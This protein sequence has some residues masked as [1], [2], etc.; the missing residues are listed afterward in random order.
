MGCQREST[1]EALTDH[2][3]ALRALLEP[4]GPASGLLPGRLAALCATPLHRV[5]LTERIVQAVGMERA[6]V[7]GTPVKHAAA[8]AL[9]QDIGNHLRALLRD[10][11]CG[12]LGLDLAGIADDL[13][14]PP[15]EP[16]V[17][18]AAPIEAVA[19]RRVVEY[20]EVVEDHEVL[21]D[22][23]LLDEGH[24]IDDLVDFVD[25]EEYEGRRDLEH[26]EDLEGFD[27]PE[28]FEEESDVSEAF[29][30]GTA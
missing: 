13:L 22:D 18:P 4:E 17:Q 21:Q 8:E 10:V 23:E 24:L 15:E 20:H 3:L 9:K 26:S 12:H 7:A 28:G 6:A 5:E 29:P 25:R 19:D 14:R 1:D 16:P 30:M 2:L 11:I 27:E